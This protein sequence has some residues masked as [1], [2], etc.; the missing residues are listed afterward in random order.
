MVC[1]ADICRTEN[2]PH[3]HVV[4]FQAVLGEEQYAVGELHKADL[5][6][7]NER[8]QRRYQRAGLP[9]VLAGVDISYN[10]DSTGW[11]PPYWQMQ[12]YGVVV[13][14]PRVEVKKRLAVNLPISDR[15][16]RPLR[17]RSC[18]ELAAALSYIIKPMFIRRVSYIDPTG[19]LN[20]RKVPIKSVQTRELAVWLD[21]YPLTARYLLTGCRRYGDRIEPNKRTCFVQK[22]EMTNINN[23]VMEQ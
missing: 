23:S 19:R 6:K 9:V 11:W 5:K 7:L 15:I 1:I 16:P 3:E 2:V 8:L 17:V 12:V 14:M 10:E 20:T 18:T 13:G 22:D 21:Q 4:A